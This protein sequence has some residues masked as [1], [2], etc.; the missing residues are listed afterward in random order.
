MCSCVMVSHGTE[1]ASRVPPSTPVY[2]S[3]PKA[4]QNH[5]LP[6]GRS[7][8]MDSTTYPH[9]DCRLE[10]PPAPITAGRTKDR[11][12]RAHQVWKENQ[13]ILERISGAKPT[14]QLT[15][16]SGLACGAPFYRYFFYT[17]LL[18]MR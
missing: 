18:L 17:S 12:L 9:I 7:I 8:A 14:P 4:P 2:R 10:Q 1:T 11:Q 16:V 13:A 6:H 3:G 5:P 15:A